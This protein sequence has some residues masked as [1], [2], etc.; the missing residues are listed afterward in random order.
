MAKLN[1]LILRFIRK[2]SLINY[3]MAKSKQRHKKKKVNGQQLEAQRKNEY[4]RKIIRLAKLFGAEDVL[5]WIPK[6]DWESF[7]KLFYE[8][9][10]MK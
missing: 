1:L 10:V 3:L 6:K 8:H 9:L 4:K 7:T 2:S 5:H